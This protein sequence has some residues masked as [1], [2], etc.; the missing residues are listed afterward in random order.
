[1]YNKSNYYK[2]CIFKI[3]LYYY[4][5]LNTKLKIYLNKLKI[6]VYIKVK[7]SKQGKTHTRKLHT[8]ANYKMKC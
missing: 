3:K 2:S 5:K 7:H 4:S 1:M 8:P 6:E